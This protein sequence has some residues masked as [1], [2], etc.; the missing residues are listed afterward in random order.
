MRLL[1]EIS[2]QT[3]RTLWAHKLRSFLTMFGIAWGVGSLLLLVGLGEGFRSGNRKQFDELGENVMFIWSG[4][5]PAVGGSFTGMRQ[6]YLT[7][8]DYLDV[9]TEAPEVKAVVPVISRGDIRAVSDYFT[10]SGQLMGVP[11]QFGQLRYMP[12][13]EGR[14]LNDF[15]DNQKRAVIVLGDEARRLLFPGHPSVGSTILLNGI[16]FEVIGTLKRIGHG[17]NNTVNLRIFIPFNTMRQYFPP[18]NVGSV[19]DAISFLNYQPRTRDVHE[20]AKTEVHKIVARNHGF[21]Y[22]IPEAFDEWDTIKTVDQVGKIFDAMNLFLGSVGLVTLALGAI[23]IINI[24]LVAVADRT[25]EIGLRKALGATNRSIMFQFFIEGA[26]LTLLSGGLGMGGAAALMA[27]LSTLP[28]PPGFDTPK[29]VPTTAALAIG[30]LAF[31]GVVAGLYPARKA[32]TLQPVDAL[33]K[34]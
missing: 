4:R 6:Y 22:T 2:S 27:A 31:A 18:L 23:G 21:D 10:S 34:E 1:F 8:K 32:A 28:Q 30:S 24:M 15:D 33:R 29:L 26:F 5:A 7:Y 3:L 17:D 16:R 25:R 11:A 20:A 13:S 12:M 19:Q 9:S 14:W